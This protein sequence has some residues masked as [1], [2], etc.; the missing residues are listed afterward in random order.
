V[1]LARRDESAGQAIII[2]RSLRLDPSVQRIGDLAVS[3]SCGVLVDQRRS[4]TVLS[5]PR[6]E[7]RTRT[8]RASS[9]AAGAGPSGRADRAAH[10]GGLIPKSRCDF[11]RTQTLRGHLMPL[12]KP[13]VTEV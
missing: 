2:V 3:V 6:L 12:S 11:H 10:N 1:P 4:V 13:T 8:V 9:A 5:H 7:V